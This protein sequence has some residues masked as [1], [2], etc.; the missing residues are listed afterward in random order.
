MPVSVWYC[1]LLRAAPDPRDKAGGSFCFKRNPAKH[2]GTIGQWM[3]GL[4]LAALDRQGKG[5]GT[6]TEPV[7]GF[8]QIHPA[9]PT[10]KS[11]WAH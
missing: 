10:K 11:I 9:V 4:D 5:S 8:R 7:S 1:G 3:L 6:D 2:P